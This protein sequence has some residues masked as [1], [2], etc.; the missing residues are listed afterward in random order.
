MSAGLF[1]ALLSSAQPAETVKLHILLGQS[2]MAGFADISLL[3]AEFQGEKTNIQ[4][5]NGTAFESL[6]ST[7][8]NNMY[9]I[10]N[11]S[12]GPEFSYLQHIAESENDTIYCLKLAAGAS[13]LAMGSGN[14]AGTNPDALD[15]NPASVDGLYDMLIDELDAAKAYL[16]ANNKTPSVKAFFLGLGENDSSVSA[17]ASAYAENLES[18]FFSNLIPYIQSSFDTTLDEA[19]VP[20]LMTRLNST[21]SL[22]TFP[23]RDT[24][25]TEQLT[26]YNAHS[27][28]V[29]I[30]TDTL[31]ISGYHYT[32]FGFVW[33]GTAAASLYI[34]N[35]GTFQQWFNVDPAGWTKTDPANSI[36]I[37]A[38]NPSLVF[39][40]AH[41]GT[42]AL[43]TDKFEWD[44]LLSDSGI[45][46]IQTFMNY[47]PTSTSNANHSFVLYKDSSNFVRISA[48]N[49]TNGTMYNINVTIGGVT[50]YALNTTNVRPSNVKITYDHDTS[51]IKM[52]TMP[53]TTNTWTQMGTTQTFDLGTSLKLLFTSNDAAANTGADNGVYRQTIYANFD[54]ST[55]YPI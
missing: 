44:T 9:F 54:Y 35:Y 22:I 5:W 36:T 10:A 31:D 33:M 11:G 3:P 42:V 30:D 1:H 28:C 13:G 48:R 21:I 12:F 34:Q 14:V 18:F 23:Y 40:A 16:T 2:N 49:L 37:T 47:N 41:T 15:W 52:Y 46:S 6:N 26:F 8:N 24:L 4:I 55:Q 38:G 50:Q 53:A 43:F 27:N 20:I 32:A 39:N 29:L 7:L 45:I 19:A 51:Q 17:W 25:R